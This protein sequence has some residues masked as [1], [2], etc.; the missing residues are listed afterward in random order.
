[1]KLFLDTNIWV[2]L[3]LEDDEGLYKQAYRVIELV[4]EGK[5]RPYTSTI[6]FLEVYFVLTSVYKLKKEIAI[7][8]LKKIL[9][10]KGLTLIEK[11]DFKKALEVQMQ[12]GLK[13][14]DCMI[15]TQIPSGVVLCTFDE[16]LLRKFKG[17]EGRTPGGLVN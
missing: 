2:R 6:V 10:T 7:E 17:R 11:T 4:E 13:L 15:V 3:F 5:F 14:T 9:A 12:T 8:D 16:A 1:M